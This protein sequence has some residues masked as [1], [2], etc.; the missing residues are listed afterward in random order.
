MS[1]R[2]TEISTPSSDTRELPR[3]N[4]KAAGD[5]EIDGGPQS[6]PDGTGYMPNVSVTTAEWFS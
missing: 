6:E 4:E 2:P 3:E 5:G 1:V